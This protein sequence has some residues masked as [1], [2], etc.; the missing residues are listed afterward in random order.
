MD[1]P[2]AQTPVNFG[3]KS[4]Y[5]ISYSPNPSCTPNLKLL[6]LVA[7][8]IS[9]GFNFLDAPLV[10]ALANFGRKYYFVVSYS[11]NPSWMLP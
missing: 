1:A 4:C 10:Q 7:A 9:R 2:L 6:A 5:V 8:K 3:S 11:P